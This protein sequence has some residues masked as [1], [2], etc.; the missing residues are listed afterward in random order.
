MYGGVYLYTIKKY[1]WQ[2]AEEL[3][4]K[5]NATI[6]VPDYPLTPDA[7]SEDTIDFMSQVYQELLMKYS[8]ENIVLLGDS[9]RGGFALAF[10]MNLR[11]NTNL[12]QVK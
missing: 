7:D 4:L 2:F 10:V 6:V 9:S 11:N 8:S 3:L 12:N 1:H 5:T